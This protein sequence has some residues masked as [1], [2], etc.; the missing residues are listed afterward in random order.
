[1]NQFD[2][3]IVGAGP[4]GIYT[5]TYA[6]LKGMNVLVV[7][8]NDIIGGQPIHLYSHKSVYDFPGHLETNGQE[9]I[10][11]LLIQQ[12][13]LDKHIQYKLKT[14]IIEWK[15]LKNEL[16]SIKLSNKE[17]IQA[18]AIIIATGN[19]SLVPNEIDSNL[20][21][22]NVNKSKLSYYVDQINEYKNKNIVLLGGGDSA[23]E[24][25]GQI[26]SAKKAKSV[27]IIHRK[28]NYRAH[29]KY[30]NALA[31]NN[32][33]QYLNYEIKEINNKAI[34]VQCNE[35]KKIKTI[36]YDKIIIQYGL[37]QQ[38]CPFNNWEKLKMKGNK[39]ITDRNQ[40]TNEKNIY[41]IGLSTYYEGRPNLLVIGIAE[42]VIAIKHI[43]D[44]INPYNLDYIIK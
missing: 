6:A 12:K 36:S 9:I 16:F 7:E 33:I 38:K 44:K 28:P 26:A 2:I 34:V 25:A 37:K 22:K 30:I 32:V 23:V 29:Q 15:R 19:G 17:K 14:S 39:F 1:M 11:N 3:I 42:G 41:A 43:Y 5:A 27:S 40:Q 18:K 4:S 21:S 8:S 24:W 10:N 31:R 35:N 13:G 20:L